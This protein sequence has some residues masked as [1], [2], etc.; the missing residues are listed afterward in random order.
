MPCFDPKIP[1]HLLSIQKWFA[2]IV[3]RPLD[4]ESRMLPFSPAGRPLFEEAVE[5][6][7]PNRRLASDQRIQI[8]NQQYWWRLLTIL[9]ENF[10]TLTRLFGYVDFNQSM[11]IPFLSKYPSRHW[12]L[13]KL[14][15]QLPLWIDEHY[16]SEDK[17]LVLSAAEVDWAYQEIFF[18]PKPFSLTPSL[19]LLSKKLY[20]QPHLKLFT[21]PFDLFSFRT[22][23]LKE[24]VEF[25][26]EKEFPPLP[27]GNKYFFLLYRNQNNFIDYKQVEEGQW[28][29]LHLI[30]GGLS[31]EDACDHLEGAGGKAAEEAQSS[32]TQ[33]IQEWLKEKWLNTKEEV[34][35]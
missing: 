18:A 7:S 20:L 29:L 27:K 4:R 30:S 13:S 19:D 9:H 26:L 3:V 17:Q 33:W 25:W 28:T 16:I 11:G 22:A 10:P 1:H 12:S 5:F 31:I 15:D 32:L 23:F 35:V 34:D 21:L 24:T 8:Y 2:S 6:I 14:G